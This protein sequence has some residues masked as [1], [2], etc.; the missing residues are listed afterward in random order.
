MEISLI[1]KNPVLKMYP[2]AFSLSRPE[3]SSRLLLLFRFIM[4]F[5]LGLWNAFYAMFI[6][7]VLFVDFWIVVISGKSPRPLWI[8]LEHY[9][10]FSI[11]LISYSWILSDRYPPFHGS[12]E[13]GYPVQVVISYSENLSR[14]SVFFRILLV[15]PHLFWAIFYGMTVGFVQFLNFWAV[16]FV[17]RMPT[18]FW[19]FI[20]R[21][22]IYYSRLQAYLLLLI[23]E[24]PP[25]HGMQPLSMEELFTTT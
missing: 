10:R 6:G 5:P 25:F 12:P 8:L 9:F 22:F 1:Q 18:V 7:V 19:G 4:I 11:Q 13:T 15:I 21:Y 14:L 17:G 3:R 16:L 20:H 24:Y 23:D 2:V